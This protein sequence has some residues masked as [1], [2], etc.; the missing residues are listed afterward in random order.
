LFLETAMRAILGLVASV[1]ISGTAAAAD[2]ARPMPVKAPPLAI[3]QIWDGWYGGIHGGY[4]W[5]DPTAT[6]NPATFATLI[7]N[8]GL[9]INGSSGP[10]SLSVAPE[11]GFGGIQIGRNWQSGN[12]VYGVELDA[13]LA[14]I[15]DTAARNFSVLASDPDNLDFTGTFFLTRKIDALGTL[16]GRLG[17]ANNTLLIYGTAGLAL[18]HVKTTMGVNNIVAANPAN[19]NAGFPAA[20]NR[21]VSSSD[22]QVGVALGAGAE[23][24]FS[25]R[26]SLKGE[27][28]F[29]WLG[30]GTSLAFTGATFTDTNVELH[31]VR[32]GLNYKFSP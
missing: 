13:S 10:F 19:F 9:T 29:I 25:P 31:T 20:L 14:D 18:G 3:A 17:W 6:F 15:A 8:G 27:Y 2:M 12:W 21:S 26:W 28:Q 16:R 23:W 24:M 7:P 30:G 22:T 1:M 5:N 4:G 32:L 11:G